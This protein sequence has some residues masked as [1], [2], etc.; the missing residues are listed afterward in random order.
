MITITTTHISELLDPN[1]GAT[2]IRL[3]Q[4]EL[5][6]QRLREQARTLFEG[7]TTPPESSLVSNYS[8]ICLADSPDHIWNQFGEILANE[9]NTKLVPHLPI[10]EPVE[11]DDLY[12]THYPSSNMGVGCHRDTNCKGLVLSYVLEGVLP[13][14]VC[15]DKQ[16]NHPRTMK[17]F[18][19]EILII[20][21]DKVGELLRPFH[22]VG[23]INTPIL[24]LGLRQYIN[25]K[26]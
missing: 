19:G 9:L 2:V 25:P 16:M 18:Q 6:S 3:N 23:K 10:S 26:N 14:S 13:F 12:L 22:F 7:F 20:R 15:A 24:Q 8:F 1:N 4:T 5:K 21:A 17:V 11:F